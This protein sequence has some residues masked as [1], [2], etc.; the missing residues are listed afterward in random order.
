V[1]IAFNGLELGASSGHFRN[2]GLLG[3]LW[4]FVAGHG[5]LELFAIFVAGAAG[6]LLGTA[7]IAPGDYRRRD[8]LALQGRRVVPMITFTVVLLVIAGLV[9]GFVSTSAAPVETRL[10]IT[11][12]SVLFLL[13]YLSRGRQKA[14]GT[15]ARGSIFTTQS[16]L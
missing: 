6:F 13:S 7:L 3:Y 11:V 4:T 5:A 15:T 16:P 8:A 10:V 14:Q 12:L 1:S 2:V 9:E